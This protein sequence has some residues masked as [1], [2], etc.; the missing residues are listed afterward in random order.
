MLMFSSTPSVAVALRKEQTLNC[1]FAI[2]HKAAHLT[3]EWNLLRHGHHSKLFSYSSRTGKSEGTGVSVKAIAKGD[4]SLKIPLTRDTSE[5]MYI[6]SVQVPPLSVSH[7]I[8]LH[9]MGEILFII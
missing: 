1:E 6:C 9:V 2:D 7:S 3:V 5:G 4:A 8:A